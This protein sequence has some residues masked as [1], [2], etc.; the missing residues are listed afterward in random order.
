MKISA[1]KP[2]RSSAR[3]LAAAVVACVLAGAAVAAITGPK[4]LLAGAQIGPPKLSSA[5]AQLYQAK[6][7]DTEAAWQAV[8]NNF[9][10]ASPYLHNLAKQGLVYFYFHNQHYDKAIK[11]LEELAAQEGF[12]TFGIAGL[13]VAYTNLNDD[14]RAY[15]ENQRLS[16]DMRS[17]LSQ[18]APAM[19]TQLSEA[20]DQLADRFTP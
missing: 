1:A 7:V 16:T 3:W 11:P 2:K 17:A 5:W 20:L 18:Q 19:A 10:E 4:S 13:V 15:E 12:K 6:Q 9:P 14:D 8:I